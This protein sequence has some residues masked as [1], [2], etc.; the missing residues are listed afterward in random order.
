MLACLSH[1]HASSSHRTD[2]NYAISAAQI[3]IV[4]Q[5]SSDWSLSEVIREFLQITIS[6]HNHSS[7][8]IQGPWKIMQKHES[9]FENL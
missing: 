7:D 6:T 8:E 4:F 3:C 2:Q 1:P 5:T 9:W